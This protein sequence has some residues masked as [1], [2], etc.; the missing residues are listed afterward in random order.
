MLRGFGGPS[1]RVE[2]K[3]QLFDYFVH[4][5]LTI[6]AVQRPFGLHGSIVPR[7]IKRY[8]LSA[9]WF[10]P[11]RTS[12]MPK[13]IAVIHVCLLTVISIAWIPS[14]SFACEC[15]FNPPGTPYQFDRPNLFSSELSERDPARIQWKGK[16]YQLKLVSKNEAIQ[17]KP[18]A[19]SVYL[20]DGS[21]APIQV[22]VT[23]IEQ[24][25]TCFGSECEYTPYSVEIAVTRDG[26]TETVSAE[27]E[28]GC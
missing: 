22:K 20:Y 21:S 12:T 5:L 7:K 28:C 27:G 11:N 9:P 6:L 19:K 26:R 14:S 1:E 25:P 13:K 15:T 18:G 2:R 17:S 8:V 10:E 24:N 16:A 4:C 3:Q 23:T